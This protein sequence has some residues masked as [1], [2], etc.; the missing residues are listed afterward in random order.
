MNGIQ[1]LAPNAPTPFAPSLPDFVDLCPITFPTSLPILLHPKRS[2]VYDLFD[3]YH[4][5]LCSTESFHKD[6]DLDT[7][8]CKL[9]DDIAD[10]YHR[11]VCPHLKELS[12]CQVMKKLD[13]Q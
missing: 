4:F 11:F 8:S 2:L 10:Y 12:P 9:C 6:I 1:I 13:S 5:K 7:C 3:L